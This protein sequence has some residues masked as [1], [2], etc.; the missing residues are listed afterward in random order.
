MPLWIPKTWW[1]GRDVFVIGGGPSLENF[2]WGRLKYE[3]TIGCNN[4]Y[5]LGADICKICFFGDAKWFEVHRLQLVLYSKPK[6]EGY[7]F[8]SAPVLMRSKLPWLWLLQRTAKGL[9]KGNTLGWNKNS[10]A[11]AIN[12]ALTLGA[13]RVY[14]LGF[15][16]H[17]SKRGF[18]NWHQHHIL[19]P[20]ASIYP[21]F[22]ERFK[23]VKDDLPKKFPGREII[24][25][26]NNSNLVYFPKVEVDEFFSERM[27]K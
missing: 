4:A 7:V 8:T 10:G 2:D 22:V 23:D 1:E 21:A 6:G 24:N 14:L 12:L 13:K 15:D 27:V 18:P 20:D 9:E 17:L 16:M 25:V 11:S 19:P 26:T 3:C 5:T